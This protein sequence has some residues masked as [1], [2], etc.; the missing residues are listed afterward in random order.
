MLTLARSIKGKEFMYNAASA[1]KVSKR[2]AETIKAALNSM[3][4]H[5][6]DNEVW[7][8]HEVDSYDNAYYFAEDQSFTIYNG[9]IKDKYL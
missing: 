1:H 2:S 8:L 5:L 4:Y 6:K 9:K 3:H 7:S